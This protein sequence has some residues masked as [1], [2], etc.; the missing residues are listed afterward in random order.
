MTRYRSWVLTD[1]ANDVWLDSFGISNVELRLPTPHDWFLR[2]RTLH[3]GL[4]QGVELLEVHNGALYFTVLPTRGM[5][6]WRGEYRGH[7]LGW[8]APLQGPVHPSFVHPAT[9]G[10]LGWLHGF[11]EWL[12]RCGLAWM[13]PPGEDV[14]SDAAGRT[15]R[16]HLTL[17]GRIANLPAHYLEV[18]VSLDPPFE[19]SVIG[20][21]E[22]A[23]LFHSRL[24]LTTTYTTLPGTNRL[25][26]HDVIE[27]RG[28]Q[29]AEMELL[30]H[31][32][33]GPPLLG[34]GSRLFLPIREMAPLNG[35]AAEGI[36]SFATYPPPTPG[37]VEQVY[38]FDLLADAAGH[39][40][41]LLANPA[42]DCGLVLRCNRQELPCFTVWRQA[43]D[44]AEG[45][46]TGLEP[47][48]NFPNFRGY[49]RQQ[50]R[51]RRLPPGG[52]FRCTWSLEVQDSAAG[53]AAA[54]AEIVTLQ[55]QA[56]PCIHRQPHPRFS[57]A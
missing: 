32:N 40:L 28:G 20:K 14:Y 41:V 38:C 21:V 55:A 39:T 42:G 52:Q 35:R 11:D 48:T 24:H 57:P 26:I 25:V 3:D 15:Q 9:S 51:V 22:E 16:Q 33:L 36:D 30:Y 1:I 56:P 2:K 4:R 46:V 8:S 34:A 31:C 23:G 49:E 44:L 45:Y 17:H 6:L 29:P 27:N 37:F 19:I 54:Q 5:G 47:G 13:G 12:C 7:Y 53:V 10:G 43:G 50:G 18:R